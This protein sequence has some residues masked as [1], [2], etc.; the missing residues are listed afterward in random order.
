MELG[1]INLHMRRHSSVGERNVIVFLLV[2]LLVQYIL[3]SDAKGT[4]GALLVDLGSTTGR[5]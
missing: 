4:A 3:L 2:H 1:V 5:L